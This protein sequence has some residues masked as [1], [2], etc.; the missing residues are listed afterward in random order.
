MKKIF[1]IVFGALILTGCNNVD[2][3]LPIQQE[4][5]PSLQITNK[6]GIKLSNAFV[7]NEVSM[8]VKIE[9]AGKAVIRITDISNRVVSKEEVDLK[10]GDNILSVYTTALP[11]SAYRIALYDNKGIRLGITDF[12]KI[13]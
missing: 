2:D 7:T 10:V 4:V 3:I 8:N 9:N 1:I 12:N 13:N 11:S 5:N 6:V